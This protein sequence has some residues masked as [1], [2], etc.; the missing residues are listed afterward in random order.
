MNRKFDRTFTN[1]DHLEFEPT[2]GRQQALV[3]YKHDLQDRQD[4]VLT[5]IPT[6]RS[7]ALDLLEFFVA[8]LL[9]RFGE[10]E[11][12]MY[13]SS[14]FVYHSLVSVA[15]NF[16]LLTPHEVVQAVHKADTALNN[17]E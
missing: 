1:V 2:A 9:D 3:H 8:N 10:L 5:H 15:L 6:S 11:D 17:K 14:D 16:G 13:D 7:Q 4:E 12:A